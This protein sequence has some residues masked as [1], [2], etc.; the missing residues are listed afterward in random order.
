MIIKSINQI[1]ARERLALLVVA[2]KALFVDTPL[3]CS[4][5][6]G[7]K[8]TWRTWSNASLAF[9]TSSV[10]QLVKERGQEVPWIELWHIPLEQKQMFSEFREL[11]FI[12]IATMKKATQYI[13]DAAE[14]PT[15]IQVH[16]RLHHFLWNTVKLHLGTEV[17]PSL[18]Y[19]I[20]VCDVV[21]IQDSLQLTHHL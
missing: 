8:L 19:F 18:L 10:G 9:P 14:W 20:Y 2:Q 12:L 4:T 11:S 1:M 5:I 6:F 7:N 16:G 17:F 21:L 13:R 3:D 15:C